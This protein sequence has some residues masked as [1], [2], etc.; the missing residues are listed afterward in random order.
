MPQKSFEAATVALVCH[1]NPD[2]DTVG[3]ALALKAVLEK[4]SK[5]AEI[6][7]TIFLTKSFRFCKI[8]KNQHVIREKV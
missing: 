7:A 5:T 1:V 3:A 6:F 8:L 2:G 4:L